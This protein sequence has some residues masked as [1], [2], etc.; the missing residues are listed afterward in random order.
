MKS[1]QITFTVD[2]S[3][4]LDSYSDAY[5][6][7]LWHIAQANPAPIGDKDACELVKKIGTEIIRRWLSN[8]PAELY[9]HQPENHFWKTLQQNGLW[10]D[11]K[12]T[13]NSELPADIA[14]QHGRNL[15]GG[16][17]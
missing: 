8:T 16:E 4:G 1:V 2:I 5:I 6:A 17:L 12:W 7:Q 13:H 11:G 15:E 9:H 3:Y 10:L 14:K